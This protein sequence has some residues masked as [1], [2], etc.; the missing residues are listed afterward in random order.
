MP[1]RAKKKAGTKAQAM[2]APGRLPNHRKTQIQHL[3]KSSSVVRT[4]RYPFIRR[5][6]PLLAQSRHLALFSP[7][8]KM[9]KPARSNKHGLD[10]KYKPWRRGKSSSSSS[11]ATKN[12]IKTH[13]EN[14]NDDG[15]ED[16]NRRRRP[17]SSGNNSNCNS[18]HANNNNASLKNLLRSQKRLLDKL[19]RGGEGNNNNNNNR[20]ALMGATRQKIHQLERDIRAHEA[21][22]REKKNAV[23]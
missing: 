21:K 6:R 23:K 8:Y 22:E 3:I 19:Q 11:S 2:E 12:I 16:N 18:N 15:G 13:N 7:H 20:E 5:G 1:R 10:R 4:I 9:K 17:T 14:N